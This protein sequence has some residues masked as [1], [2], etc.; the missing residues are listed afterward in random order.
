MAKKAGRGRPTKFSPELA[1][2]ILKAL[3]VGMLVQDAWTFAGVPESTYYDWVEMG[4]RQKSGP[5][6]E[7]SE[8]VSKARSSAKLRAV[9]AVHTGMSKDW[10]AAA[11]WLGVTDP[12]NYGPKIRVT[13][14]QEFSDALAR[15]KQ[16][17]SPE[18]FETVLDAIVSGGSM[19]GEGTPG[20]GEGEGGPHTP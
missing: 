20:G 15:I 4:A 12:K 14:E 13:L 2:E 1:A 5:L 6:R 10:K 8:A 9:G 7:F 18:V 3:K 19:E 16:R 11:W 17:V